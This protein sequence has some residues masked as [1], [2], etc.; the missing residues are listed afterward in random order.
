V[1]KESV[2]ALLELIEKEGFKLDLSIK[3]VTTRDKFIW[4]VKCKN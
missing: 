1:K 2:R 4:E 3:T